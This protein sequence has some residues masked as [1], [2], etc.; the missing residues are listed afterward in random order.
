MS[1]NPID[2][3]VDDDRGEVLVVADRLTG[4][5]GQAQNGPDRGD[6]GQGSSVGEARDWARGEARGHPGDRR[7]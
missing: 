1:I 5:E 3:L 7:R 6:Q 4:D 2:R